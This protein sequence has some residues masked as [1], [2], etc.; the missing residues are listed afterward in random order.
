MKTPLPTR[1]DFLGQSARTSAA[2]STLALASGNLVHAAGGSEKLKLG[3]VGCGGRGAGAANQ[4][5]TAD[6][7]VTLPAVCDVNKEGMTNAHAI[8]EKG[9]PGRIDVP[10]ERRYNDFEGYKRVIAECD[11]VI[12]ATSP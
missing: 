8:L 10:E 12:L 4:A 1:R 11:V 2:L 6:D 9:K 5:L 7:G 3:L